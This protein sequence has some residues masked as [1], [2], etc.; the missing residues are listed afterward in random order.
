MTTHEVPQW[1]KAISRM[2]IVHDDE[3]KENCVI[4]HMCAETAQSEIWK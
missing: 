2:D 3:I 1:I 4:L